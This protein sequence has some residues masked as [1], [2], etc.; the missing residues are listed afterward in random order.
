MYIY[1]WGGRTFNMQ[2]NTY[3]NYDYHLPARYA[4]RRTW[5]ALRSSSSRRRRRRGRRTYVAIRSR[6]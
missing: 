5:Y 3:K 1:A 2:V 4:I 6:T